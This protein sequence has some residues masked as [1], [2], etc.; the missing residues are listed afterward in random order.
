MYNIK[1][2]KYEAAGVREY[3]IVD[4]E[5]EK[6]IVYTLG[7]ESDVSLYGFDSE[8]PVEIYEGERRIDFQRIVRD[9]KLL[10]L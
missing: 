10:H 6:V 2:H 4:P 7:E 1:L 9:L 3:W 5:K 8:I